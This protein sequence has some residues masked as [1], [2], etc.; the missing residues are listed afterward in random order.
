MECFIQLLDETDIEELVWE[1]DGVKVAFKKGEEQN[2]PLKQK[3]L[4]GKTKT[5]ERKQIIREDVQGKD[6]L[7]SQLSLRDD[8]DEYVI[9]KS[10]MVGT[11]HILSPDKVPLVKKGDNIRVGQKIYIIEAMKILKGITAEIQGKIVKI[12]IENNHAVEYGQS[13][14]LIDPRKTKQQEDKNV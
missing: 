3:T 7:A 12:L 9:I 2:V 1:K 10:P 8:T 14:F 13:L 5:E 6:E 4:K 11:F